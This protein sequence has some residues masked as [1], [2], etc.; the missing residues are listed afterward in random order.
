MGIGFSNIADIAAKLQKFW[1][2]DQATGNVLT[3]QGEGVSP[4]GAPAAGG[5]ADVS[6]FDLDSAVVTVSNTVVDTTVW[7]AALPVRTYNDGEAIRIALTGSFFNGTA[8][9]VSYTA[10]C[11]IGGSE[12]AR[13]NNYNPLA[14]AVPS[15]F[16]AIEWLSQIEQD[17]VNISIQMYIANPANGGDLND[18]VVD[19]FM[20]YRNSLPASVASGTVFSLTL[21]MDA[22]DVLA[23]SQFRGAVAELLT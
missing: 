12:G 17:N 5:A 2:G 21:A 9:A 19:T 3:F 13:F 4:L 20:V 16:W 1:G 11:R 14:V 10:R 23:L 22:A 15:Y 6:V 8:G 7:S 18:F